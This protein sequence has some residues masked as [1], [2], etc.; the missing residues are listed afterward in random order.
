MLLLTVLLPFGV[1]LERLVTLFVTAPANNFSCFLVRLPFL[2]FLGG[3]LGLVK[4][5]TVTERLSALDSGCKCSGIFLRLFSLPS[6]ILCSDHLDQ[7]VK[8]FILFFLQATS[9]F[10][11]V[12]TFWE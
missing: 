3:T 7:S 9:L 6:R 8:E 4:P 1:A 2:F 5:T 12:P 10:E 11:R